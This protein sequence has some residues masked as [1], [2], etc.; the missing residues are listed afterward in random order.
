MAVAPLLVEQMRAALDAHDLDAFV[1]FFH[2][3]YSGERPRHPGS[4]NSNR[5]EVRDNWAEVIRDVPDLRVEIP[6]AVQEGDTIWSEWRVY[7][8]A[9]SGAMLELRGVIIF[10]VQAGRVA[11][12]RR[13]LEPVEQGG[14]PLPGFIEPLAPVDLE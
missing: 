4:R 1:A 12:S 8:T 11:W 3:D 9:R 14:K 7:G 13:Y 6:A 2:E 10:G 5:D